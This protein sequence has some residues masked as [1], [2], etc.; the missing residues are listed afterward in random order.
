MKI[1]A[2][3]NNYPSHNKEMGSAL[4]IKEPV[5]FLK[6]DSALLKGGKPFFLPDHLG[7]VDHEAE[8]VVR[9]SRLGKNIPERFARR[10][11]DAVTVGVDFTARDWQ[12]LLKQQ[13]LPWTLS[14]GFDGAAVIGSWLPVEELPPI[15]TLHFLLKRNGEVVQDGYAGDMLHTVDQIIAY[16]SRFMTIKTGDLVYT[17]TPAGV[18]PVHIND[19]MEGWIEDKKV[20]SFN[21]K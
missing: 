14:K 11:Y 20:L 7:R 2:V 13:Q 6:P 12:H 19:K 5:V 17:G 9:I 16:V 18:G 3:G 8:L 4:S 21:V 15:Q 10:Y 1:I